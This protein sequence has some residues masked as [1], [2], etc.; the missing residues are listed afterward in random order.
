VQTGELKRRPFSD[1]PSRSISKSELDLAV[2]IA[3]FK[4]TLAARIAELKRREEALNRAEL[5]AAAAVLPRVSAAY[6]DAGHNAREDEWW[7]RQLGRRR[8]A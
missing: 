1:P 3:D 4:A 5:A 8:S 2:R 6:F 7:S